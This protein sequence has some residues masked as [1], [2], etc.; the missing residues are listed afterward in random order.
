[1]AH[2][3]TLIHDFLH[4]HVSAYGKGVGVKW[5]GGIYWNGR[6]AL[7]GSYLA[8]FHTLILSLR[9]FTRCFLVT[10]TCGGEQNS[11]RTQ[12]VAG[13][14]TAVVQSQAEANTIDTNHTYHM[15]TFSWSG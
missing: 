8:D 7:L 3:L 14:L 2:I 12:G 15:R 13:K 10:K 6:L 4:L 5:L 9:I 1:M 11:S